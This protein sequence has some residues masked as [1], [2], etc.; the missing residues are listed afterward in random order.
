MTECEGQ[1]ADGGGETG[2]PCGTLGR[3][4]EALGKRR[5]AQFPI[6]DIISADTAARKRIH[7]AKPGTKTAQ[8]IPR[9]QHAATPNSGRRRMD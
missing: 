4:F 2:R 3:P 6:N 5:A 8:A 7:V 1:R 9:I